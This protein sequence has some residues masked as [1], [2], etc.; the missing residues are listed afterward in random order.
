MKKRTLRYRKKRI[1]IKTDIYIYIN[2]SL[3]SFMSDNREKMMKA[4]KNMRI[5]HSL[6]LF[7]AIYKELQKN[8]GG[9]GYYNELLIIYRLRGKNI[10]IKPNAEHG[11]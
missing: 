10:N 9:E 2:R 5:T 4:K 1:E 6:F 8:R 11:V 7:S 3:V